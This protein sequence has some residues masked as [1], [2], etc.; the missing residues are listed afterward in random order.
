MNTI[1]KEFLSMSK[2]LFEKLDACKGESDVR[3]LLKSSGINSAKGKYEGFDYALVPLSGNKGA[4][5]YVDGLNEVAILALN[6]HITNSNEAILQKY[7]CMKNPV[8]YTDMLDINSDNKH[9]PNSIDKAMELYMGRSPDYYNK[10]NKKTKHNPNEG[11]FNTDSSLHDLSEILVQHG[12]TEEEGE[13]T[14]TIQDYGIGQ[15]P[16]TLVDTMFSSGKQ[17][18]KLH[19]PYLTGRHNMGQKGII[20]HLAGRKY[21]LIC[22]KLAPC[23]AEL[24]NDPHK[25][26]WSFSLNM[27]LNEDELESFGMPDCRMRSLVHLVFYL[28]G[29][30][31]VPMFDGTFNAVKEIEKKGQSV[32]KFNNPEYG[33]YKKMYSVRTGRG[34]KKI[35]HLTAKSITGRSALTRL[36]S[37][38]SYTYPYVVSPVRFFSPPNN[39]TEGGNT[40]IMLGLEYELNS[41]YGTLHDKIH[42]IDAGSVVYNGSHIK[43][44]VYHFH[45]E[46]SSLD[47]SGIVSKIYNNYVVE[48]PQ[49]FRNKD[50]KLQSLENE[51]IVVCDFNQLK[52]SDKNIL[53]TAGRETFRSNEE[54]EAL[55]TQI[56]QTIHSLPEIKALVDEKRR[57]TLSNVTG[58]LSKYFR[59]LFASKSNKRENSSSNSPSE[60]CPNSRG[61]SLNNKPSLMRVDPSCYTSV[62][63]D[64]DENV[65]VEKKLINA[66]R[67]QFQLFFQHDA[68]KSF[69]EK[70]GIN[71][72]V[73]FCGDN[74]VVENLNHNG[75]FRVQKPKDGIIALTLSQSD[76]FRDEDFTTKII[77]SPK[78]SD[79]CDHPTWTFEIPCRPE[80]KTVNNSSGNGSGDRG[81][82]SGLTGNCSLDIAFVENESDLEKYNTSCITG[83]DGS[84]K[85]Y[86]MTKKDIFGYLENGDSITWAINSKHPSLLNYHNSISDQ[87]SEDYLK[88]AFASYSEV[89]L[90]ELENSIKSK[91][92]EDKDK[93]INLDSINYTHRYQSK[94]WQFILEKVSKDLI[95]KKS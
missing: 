16:N 7:H 35:S 5:S 74:G 41:K 79:K 81:S 21:Q 62:K 49:N 51:L 95:K 15:S 94:N 3:K 47:H 72:E 90:T 37:V 66:N 70:H 77:F 59:N 30:A 31:V 89:M 22:S 24:S 2:R 85:F 19:I 76:Q 78:N 38:M 58:K 6:E 60:D 12:I 71:I 36:K 33:T 48:C 32:S 63:S 27:V 75:L 82:N 42:K 80:R 11:R 64:D 54:Y 83:R 53:L 68:K 67:P 44:D 40:S 26:F 52:T 88:K 65:F 34:I 20:P 28:D 56:G 61:G 86:S 1:S 4:M 87:H 18:P 93:T 39:D 17:S 29:E 50:F 91:Q 13:D 69:F 46:K 43:L 25:N 84:P 45:K 8:E 73:A 92:K 14:I 23:T 10:F 9:L 55:R 57:D